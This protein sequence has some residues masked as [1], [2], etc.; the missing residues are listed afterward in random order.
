MSVIASVISIIGPD[1]LREIT[2]EITANFI[3]G[4]N[5]QKITDIAL[6]LVFLYSLSLIIGY[7]QGYIMATITN[8]T[9]KRLRSGIS[10]KI[11]KLPLKYFV[12][13]SAFSFGA[14]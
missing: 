10:Q 3:V 9:S 4:I 2:S 1:K 8:K 6:I 13:I 11:N 5:L 14:E 7:I 12:I